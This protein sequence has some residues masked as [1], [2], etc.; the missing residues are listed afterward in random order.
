MS[1]FKLSK[2]GRTNIEQGFKPSVEYVSEGR[3]KIRIG[4]AMVAEITPDITGGSVVYNLTLDG[5]SGKLISEYME[6]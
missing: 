6:P 3:Y 1:K 4:D 2:A 5:A